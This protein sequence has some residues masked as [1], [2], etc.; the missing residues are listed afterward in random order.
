MDISVGCRVQMK[1][2][3][4]CGCNVFLVTRIGM[5]FKIKCQ[6]CGREIMMPRSSCEK[7]IKKVLSYPENGGEKHV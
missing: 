7:G 4:P 6:Q 5:D 3:H 2:N 1:K